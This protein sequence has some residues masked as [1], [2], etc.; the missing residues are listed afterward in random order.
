MNKYAMNPFLQ[1]IAAKALQL[2]GLGNKVKYKA[3]YDPLKVIA[4]DIN[5]KAP[6]SYAGNL[7]PA[8]TKPSIASKA[9]NATKDFAKNHPA[10]TTVAIGAPV[11]YG[12]NSMKP[13]PESAAIPTEQAI[14]TDKILDYLKSNEGLSYAGSGAG[15]ATL[16]ALL[17]GKDNRLLGATL[18]TLLGLGGNYLY[19]NKDQLLDTTPIQAISK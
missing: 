14:T 12:L 18:G 10:T 7:I 16:G 1:R 17:A 4:E 19:Q 9:W 11:G 5:F 8:A 6:T 3:G 13:D 15:G 2:A